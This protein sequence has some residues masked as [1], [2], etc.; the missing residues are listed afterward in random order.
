MAF[1][2]ATRF[3]G[4]GILFFSFCVGSARA[5]DLTIRADDVQTVAGRIDR[6]VGERWAKENVRP[7]QAADDAEF[8]RRVYLDLTGRIPRVSEARDFLDDPSPDRRSKLVEKLLHGPGYVKHFTNQWRDLLIPDGNNQQRFLDPGFT[9]WLGRQ[10]RDDTPYDQMVREILTAPVINGQN[11]GLAF[12]RLQGQPSPLAFFQANEQKP[13]NLAAATARTFLGV[14]LECAQCH[15]H[16][17][18]KYTRKQFWELAAFFAG[19]QSQGQNGFYFAT[20][21][22]PEVHEI[23]IP[24]TEKVV[25]ARFPNGTEPSWKAGTATR[26]TL[27][28]WVTSDTNPYFA[29]A[30]VNR[31]WAHFFGIGL[32]DPVDEMG[33]DN[34]A[35]HPELLDEL[36][37]E[38]ARHR[39]DLKFLARA[40]VHSKVYQL[41]SAAPDAKPEDLRLF[42]RMPLKSLTG[43]QMFDSLAL[44]VGYRDNQPQQFRG[45]V[46]NQQS[47]RT[48][49]LSKFAL[50]GKRTEPQTSILQALTLMNGKFVGE[51]TNAGDLEKTE[52][53][54]AVVDAP[55]FDNAGRV[56]A[57]YL[58]V[59][60]RRP[61]AE[62]LSRMVRYVESGGPRKDPRA[63][64]ADVLWALLN[65][66]EFIVNH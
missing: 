31:M 1:K 34:A 53:L 64:L 61:R 6:L 66:T 5:E 42:R 32:V 18:A 43:E 17:F 60:S 41:S 3:A 23:K 13:E 59:L 45:F 48:E 15:D 35:S 19:I 26:A 51:A 29:R 54:A 63:A 10:F 22:K 21:D 57:L 46:A 12:R 14:K 38:F 2:T 11:P 58:T 65:S 56:E 36:A 55:F 47:P 37:R 44:A 4:L 20:G 50:N 62:E 24:G 39:F 27:A 33:E 7:T 25:Q 40:I 52:T 28:D 9:T 8:L 49:F 30:A 16:P